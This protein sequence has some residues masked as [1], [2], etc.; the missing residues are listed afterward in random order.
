M[1]SE[2]SGGCLVWV[3]LPW[4]HALGSICYFQKKVLQLGMIRK[5]LF[6]DVRMLFVWTI[7]MSLWILLCFVN[8]VRKMLLLGSC[9]SPQIHVILWHVANRKLLTRENFN[10]HRHLKDITGVLFMESEIFITY[11]FQCIIA[12]YL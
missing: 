7:G 5:S 2:R 3:V 8:W 11:F 6:V 4:H 10:K 1:C 12:S 9:V